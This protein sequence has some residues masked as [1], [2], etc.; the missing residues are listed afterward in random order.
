MPTAGGRKLKKEGKT[1]DTKEVIAEMKV[2]REEEDD[3]RV[4]LPWQEGRK[5]NIWLLA[6]T[7]KSWPVKCHGVDKGVDLP[8]WQKVKQVK[9]VTDG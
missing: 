6:T 5:Q 2:K 1:G 3:E 9:D 7:N 8:N 4:C